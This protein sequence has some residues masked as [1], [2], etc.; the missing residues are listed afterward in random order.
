MIL[1]ILNWLCSCLLGALFL[2]SGYIKVQA[3]LQFAAAITAYKLVP[4]HLILPIATY[5]PWIEIV[6]GLALISGWKT[7]Y[8]G[9]AAALL[10]VFFIALLTITYARG[11]E[12]NCGC[13]SFDDRITPK[14]IARDGMIIIPAIFLLI[15]D[16]LRRR[17]GGMSKAALAPTSEPKPGVSLRKALAAFILSICIGGVIAGGVLKLAPRFEAIASLAASTFSLYLM[18]AALSCLSIRILLVQRLARR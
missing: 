1:R 8:T 6:L 7:R 11:I 18:W 13:F 4:D 12:A 14:T 2:Y 17:F 5:F 3:V 9:A 15:E 10:M 16:L